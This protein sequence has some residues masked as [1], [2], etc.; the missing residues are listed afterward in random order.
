MTEST[1]IKICGIS[2]SE[3]ALV[4]AQAGADMIGMIF[5]SSRRQVSPEQAATI[6][7]ALDQIEAEQRP[8]LVGVFVNADAEDILTVADYCG[9]DIIQLSGDEP[10]DMTEGL[11]ARS[12]IKTVRFKGDRS[13]E[14]WLHRS[15]HQQSPQIRLHV[16]A[17]VPG[18]YGGAGILA[19]WKRAATLAQQAPIL[20]AGGLTA[21]NV[22]E[23]IQTVRPWGVDVSSG[24]ETDGVK[25][26]RKIRLFIEAVRSGMLGPVYV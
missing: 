24:V 4:A 22:Q 2:S 14:P 8:L 13:E 16:D 25:D 9:L 21:E 7:S 19:D 23:A 5:A 18:I 15:L 3:H 20:L 1:K 17:H 6:R 12:L 26:N 10:P 11:G